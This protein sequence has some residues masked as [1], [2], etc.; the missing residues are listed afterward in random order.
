MRVFLKNRK[1][2]IKYALK[3][4]YTLYPTIVMNEHKAYW[5]F[6]WFL[7]WRMLLNKIKL[8]GVLFWGKLGLFFRTDI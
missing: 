5:T 6:D 4:K 2:F 1:G 8:P 3:H 7:K